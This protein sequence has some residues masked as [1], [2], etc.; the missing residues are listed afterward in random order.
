M[1]PDGMAFGAGVA[2]WSFMLGEINEKSAPVLRGLG[3]V[4]IL[5]EVELAKRIARLTGVFVGEVV[6]SIDFEPFAEALD[7][8][9][10]DNGA[11][12]D[13]AFRSE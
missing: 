12:S 5:A 9:A 8:I 10:S 7:L 1:I 11:I 6:G 4:G 3:R 13:G 2:D